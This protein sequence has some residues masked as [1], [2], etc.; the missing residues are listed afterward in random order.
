MDLPELITFQI[1]RKLIDR[2]RMK[3]VTRRDGSVSEFYEFSMH[4]LREPKH[5]HDYIVKQ[6]VTKEERAA[7]VE[8]PILGNPVPLVAG[9]K[10][11]GDY[12]SEQTLLR[13]YD[14][15]PNV[16]SPLLGDVT[17]PA[18]APDDAFVVQ[19]EWT[20]TAVGGM[21]G[22]S[23][24]GPSSRVGALS[25]GVRPPSRAREGE[26]RDRLRAGR[27]PLPTECIPW[28]S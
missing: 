20:V 8:M 23:L 12:V 27:G 17:I 21:S 13:F 24:T 25:A 7:R 4:K 9:V 6:S 1:D 2:A 28:R 18:L 10:N 11:I 26:P 3:T 19:A 14:D 22:A 5:G 15:H 16:G